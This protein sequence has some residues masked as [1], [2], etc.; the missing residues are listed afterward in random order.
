VRVGRRSSWPDLVLRPLIRFLRFYV[1]RGGFL[2]GLPG[3]YVALSAA[4]YVHL[5]YAKLD[6]ACAAQGEESA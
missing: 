6:E 2:A 3:L 4:V 1:W 5:K